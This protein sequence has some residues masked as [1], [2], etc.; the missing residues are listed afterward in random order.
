VKK[1][2]S[3]AADNYRAEILGGIAAQLILQA[4][5]QGKQLHKSTLITAFCDNLG[6]MHHGN[7]ANRPLAEKQK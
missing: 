5:L 1:T 2:D 6:V 4:A 3:Y 7:H